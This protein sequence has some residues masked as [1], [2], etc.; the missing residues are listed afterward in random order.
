[1]TQQ[2]E[3]A[4]PEKAFES[5]G[6]VLADIVSSGHRCGPIH[7]DEQTWDRLQ[8]AIAANDAAQAERMPDDAAALAQMQDAYSRLEK[9]GWRNAIYCPKD[10]SVFDAIE[11]G[12]TG[13]HTCH[14]EGEWPKGSWWVRDGDDLWPSRP[15]LF[16]L[17]QARGD[18]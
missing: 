2:T 5:L 6:D 12:S 7:V 14:Y 8:A 18:Q 13:I 10:G 3:Q 17:R 16:R 4:C 11:A 15:I 1:M 9:L